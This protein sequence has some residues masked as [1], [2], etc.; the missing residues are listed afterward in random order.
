MAENMSKE[1]ILSM[2]NK[3]KRSLKM[4]IERIHELEEAL[5]LLHDTIVEYQ[6][7]EKAAIMKYNSLQK[8]LQNTINTMNVQQSKEKQDLIRTYKD[9]IKVLTGE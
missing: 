5:S 7:K 8:L 1:T 4:A 9:R 6:V 3:N 2:F